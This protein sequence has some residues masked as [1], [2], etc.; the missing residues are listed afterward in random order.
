MD[1]ATV[2]IVASVVFASATAIAAA[3]AVL[4]AGRASGAPI[5]MTAGA[6]AIAAASMAMMLG[7]RGG[8]AVALALGSLWLLAGGRLGGSPGRH[9]RRGLIAGATAATCSAA[10]LAGAFLLMD[11]SVLE[12]F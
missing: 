10:S 2:L 12:Q 7:W 5:A 6:V 9:A 8:V 11:W 4:V 1:A 3:D